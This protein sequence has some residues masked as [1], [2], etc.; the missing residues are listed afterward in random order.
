MQ[1]ASRSRNCSNFAAQATSLREAALQDV[2]R[3][4]RDVLP[5]L[6]KAPLWEPLRDC[7]EPL[8]A[9][10][11]ADQETRWTKWL[12]ACLDSAPANG[13]TA[14]LL[15]RA[16]AR[17]LRRLHS[18]EGSLPFLNPAKCADALLKTD[19][20]VESEK[21]IVGGRLDLS[22]RCDAIRFI[23]EVKLHSGLSGP[24]QLHRYENEAL[25]WASASPERRVG[26]ILLTGW[27]RDGPYGNDSD[28]EDALRPGALKYPRWAMIHWIDLAR[29]LR[30]E[31]GKSDAAVGA[32]SAL[33]P[34]SALVGAVER[35]LLDLPPGLIQRLL[36]RQ[37]TETPASL[38]NGGTIS[39]VAGLAHVLTHLRE[40]GR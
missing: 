30:F 23:V 6:L 27:R 1:S 40:A 2:G 15:R 21:T 24:D 19:L 34:L 10:G 28:V 20:E 25:A 38:R 39:D 9:L 18:R 36:R 37:S 11:I 33:W 29:A 16:L 26:L 22:L 8:E 17:S 3:L 4:T 12:A 14:L 35:H 5:L 31:I 7:F 13:A 32:Q